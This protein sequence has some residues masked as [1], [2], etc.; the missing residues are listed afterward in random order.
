MEN[1]YKVLY[2]F[3]GF[4][5]DGNNPY[6]SLILVGSKLYGMTAGG[7]AS[8]GPGVIF[9][10]NLDGSGYQVILDFSQVSGAIGGPYG[11]LTL[12]GARLYGMTS[13]GGP[14]GA[15]GVIFR[16]NP[17]GT[18]FQILHGFMPTQGD[19]GQPLGD[20]TFSGSRLY[21]LDLCQWR[22]QRRRVF[23]LSTTAVGYR[24]AA[25]TPLGIAA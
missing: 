5:S 1:N 21:R 16:V 2:N 3:Q 22:F 20:V 23:L 11:S 4:P 8:N 24:D 12:W 7:G 19:G 9:S 25:I 13:G 10:I 17:D 14:G 18:G 6:G 15:S